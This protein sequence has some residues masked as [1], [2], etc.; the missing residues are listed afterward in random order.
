MVYLRQHVGPPRGL[1]LGLGGCRTGEAISADDAAWF[2]AL[3]SVLTIYR[4]C[5]VDRILGASWTLD[6]ATAV[7]FAR[8]HRGIR[9]R[10]PALAT[11]RIS[12]R[13]VFFASNDR[14]EFEV[15]GIPIA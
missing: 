7:G 4:G 1:A 12:K 11:A 9:V 15:L 3:P 13:A 6:R 8:G 14:E 2:A 10:E 5:G